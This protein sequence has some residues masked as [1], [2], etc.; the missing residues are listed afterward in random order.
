MQTCGFEVMSQPVLASLGTGPGVRAGVDHLQP[1]M[2]EES[3]VGIKQSRHEKLISTS[4]DSKQKRR[5]S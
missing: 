3:A 4:C 5:V 2:S 1:V